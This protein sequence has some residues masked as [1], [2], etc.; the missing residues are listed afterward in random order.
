MQVC[1]LAI[2]NGCEFIVITA[3]HEREHVYVGHGLHNQWA[4][5]R[6][7]QDQVFASGQLALLQAFRCL[8]LQ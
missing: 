1:V 3:L 8:P 7:C 2:M 4:A 6:T 5:C